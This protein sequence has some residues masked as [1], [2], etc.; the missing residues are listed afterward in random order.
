MTGRFHRRC[1]ERGWDCDDADHDEINVPGPCPRCGKLLRRGSPEGH[2]EDL[3]EPD[4]PRKKKRSLR[5]RGD[6][7][8]TPRIGKGHPQ[9]R[10]PE[11]RKPAKC[12]RKKRC[13]SFWKSTDGMERA[14]ASSR[15]DHR[16]GEASRKN[17]W[18]FSWKFTGLKKRREKTDAILSGNSRM[19]WNLP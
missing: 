3:A 16:P 1:H 6:D 5:L 15:Q 14:R 18:D 11:G 17:R 9:G 19:A 8:T 4:E 10:P 7:R 2:R 12:R 13:G